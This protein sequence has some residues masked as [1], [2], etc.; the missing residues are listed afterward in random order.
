MPAPWK[1][2]RIRVNLEE[3]RVSV[4]HSTEIDPA[5]SDELVAGVDRA[6]DPVYSSAA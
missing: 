1:S 3:L 6:I 5:C 4:G 2:L